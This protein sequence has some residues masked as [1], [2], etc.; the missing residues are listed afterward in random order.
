MRHSIP[1]LIALII[2]TGSVYAGMEVLGEYSGEASHGY[3]TVKAT[4]KPERYLVWLGI[5][6]GSCGGVVLIQNEEGTLR[7]NRMQF[8]H[9]IGG[10]SCIT[11]IEFGANV[12]D[13]SDSCISEESEANSTC[14]VMGRYNRTRR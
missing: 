10:K 3:L 5:G 8:T 2:P 13:V 14:A 9:H 4:A 12:A 1:I 7:D 11:T 6:S